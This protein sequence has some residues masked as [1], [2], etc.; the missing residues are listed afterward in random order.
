VVSI[1][2]APKFVRQLKKLEPKIRKEAE[3]KIEIFINKP[4]NPVLRL[5]KLHGGL[6]DCWAFSVN[7]KFRIVFEV[8]PGGEYGFLRIDDHDVYKK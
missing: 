2:Y 5:H 7:F 8:L 6:S 1:V 3:K 4:S